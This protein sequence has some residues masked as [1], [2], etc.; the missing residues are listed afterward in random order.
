MDLPPPTPSPEPSLRAELR[1]GL[2]LYNLALALAVSVL[3][4]F[5]AVML[6]AAGAFESPFGFGV[7]SEAL[8][9]GLVSMVAITV[10]H[11]G[12]HAYAGWR[13]GRGLE[14]LRRGEK[15]RAERLLRIVRWRGMEHYDPQGHARR[16]LASLHPPGGEGAAR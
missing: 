12:M 1:R 16:A 7:L 2:G 14:A 6:R 10:L 13:L 11:V 15:E 4:A 9:I 8:V 3:L 5:V